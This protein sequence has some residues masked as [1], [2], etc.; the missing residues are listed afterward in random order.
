MVEGATCKDYLQVQN[1][2]KRQVSRA[3]K[4]YNF[5]QGATQR[6]NEYLVKGFTMDDERLK[7]IFMRDWR[8]KLDA[9]LKFKMIEEKTK[10]S[11]K[12]RK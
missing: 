11:S 2:G 1:E 12:K 10:K 3:R 5:R 8:Q 4:F 6:L 7:Q 9:F